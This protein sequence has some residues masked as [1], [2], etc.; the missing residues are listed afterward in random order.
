MCKNLPNKHFYKLEMH[1]KVLYSIYTL[2]Q[3]LAKQLQLSLFLR[4]NLI[5]V[6]FELLECNINW[7]QKF[8]TK[9]WKLS[10]ML[11]KKPSVIDKQYSYQSMA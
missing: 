3:K 4:Q 8:I 11:I 9:L 6:S 10:N 7:A 1:D 2:K 5:S